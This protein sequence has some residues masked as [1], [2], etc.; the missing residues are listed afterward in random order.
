LDPFSLLLAREANV[1]VADEF[2]A[3]QLQSGLI[4]AIETGSQRVMPEA[5]QARSKF[6]RVMGWAAFGLMR[7]ALWLTGNRY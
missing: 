3:K 1:V 2:F 6:Q 5:L 4:H 7:L